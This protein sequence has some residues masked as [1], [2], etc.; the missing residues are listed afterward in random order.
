MSY[1]E[2]LKNNKAMG[3]YRRTYQRL[4]MQVKKNK[5]NEKI[6]K[7]FETWKKQDKEKINDMKKSKLTEDEVYNWIIDNK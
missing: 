5:G 7:E 6:E 3:E 2:R 1:T 4:F